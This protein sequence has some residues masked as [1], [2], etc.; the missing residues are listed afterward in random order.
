[1]DK[2]RNMRGSVALMEESN[3]EVWS[4]NE[5]IRN[6]KSFDRHSTNLKQTT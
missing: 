5:E 3:S 4:I 2:M 6:F 1:M